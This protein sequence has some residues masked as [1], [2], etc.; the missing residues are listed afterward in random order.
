[1]PNNVQRR[2]EIRDVFVSSLID[3]H[4]PSHMSKLN[5]VLNTDGVLRCSVIEDRQDG[6]YS[7][8]SNVRLRFI[9]TNTHE[10]GVAIREESLDIA[11]LG[12]HWIE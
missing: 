3:L 2:T 11:Y 9:L 10:N 12:L 7:N 4:T 5:N 8:L 1:M 6:I